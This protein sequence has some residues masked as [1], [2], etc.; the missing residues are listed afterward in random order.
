MAS[1][2]GALGG[3]QLRLPGVDISYCFVPVVPVRP[4]ALERSGATPIDLEKKVAGGRC[5]SKNRTNKRP[6]AMNRILI[7]ILYL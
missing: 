6:A 3:L 1:S 5:E 7:D 2:G 4:Q